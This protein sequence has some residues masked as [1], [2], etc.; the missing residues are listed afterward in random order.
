MTW[1]ERGRLW[2][3]DPVDYPNNLQP[4]GKGRD[5]IVICEDTKGTGKADKFTVFADKLSIPTSMCLLQGRRCIVLRR[6]AAPLFLKDTDG[7]DKADVREVLFARLGHGRHA[8]LRQQHAIWPGQLDL[9]HAGLQPFEA[10]ARRR[11]ACA[12]ARASIA[13]SR[14]G[15]RQDRKFEFL[16]STNNNTWG[17]GMS[18]EGI[19]FGS[20]ANGN[21]ER[22]H[23]DSEPLLRSRHAAGR[24]R[25]CWAASPIATSSS[26]SRDKV[27][28]VDFHGGY[29]AAAGHAL[30]TAR[31]YPQEYWNRTAFVTE[32]T[33][34]LVG[35]FVL[36]RDGSNFSSTNPFNLLAS[37]DEW[38]APIMAEVGPDGNVWV[39]DWY[40]YIVQHNPTPAGFKTGK[41]AAY[42]TDLRDKKHGRIYRIV[43]DGKPRSVPEPGAATDA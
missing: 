16:R 19:I 17:L 14:D 13:S 36:R 23:A 26:R 38:T 41:G 33:G 40:N 3:A 11:D 37:D 12:S 43:H 29:T 39:I 9:G 1:D 7:D 15:D 35:T 28:Q 2:V 10:H 31:T 27:R 8:R 32:P 21:P 24:R 5:R 6:T 30:Y 18:E 25:W 4:P 20:T 42:E 22:L 34:H